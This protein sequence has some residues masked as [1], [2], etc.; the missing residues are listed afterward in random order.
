VTQAKENGMKGWRTLG[1]NAAVALLGVAQA[2]NWTD[3]LGSS[4]T[5]GWIITG[6]GVANMVL[7][8]VTNTP[9]GQ[10]T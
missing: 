7:R 1:L 10:K 8:S 6:V 2:T 9:V 5:A 3:V 4:P